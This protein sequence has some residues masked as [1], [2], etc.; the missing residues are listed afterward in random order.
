MFKLHEDVSQIQEAIKKP[1]ILRQMNLVK[2]LRQEAKE[3]REKMLEMIEMSQEHSHSVQLKRDGFLHSVNQ[4]ETELQGANWEQQKGLVRYKT[5][6]NHHHEQ[7]DVEDY[8]SQDRMDIK[9]VAR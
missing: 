9:E 1:S 2:D 3:G 8:N 5:F 4:L 6:E 7:V